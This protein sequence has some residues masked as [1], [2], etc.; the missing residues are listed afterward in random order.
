MAAAADHATLA[1]IELVDVP[2]GLVALDALVKEAEVALY[3]A[4]DIDPGRFL[5]VF[6]GDLASCEAGLAKAIDGGRSDV[7]ESLLLPQAHL[8]LRAALSG[9]LTQPSVASEAQAAL[10]ILQ[11]HTPTGTLAATD[12]ALKAAEVSLLRLR[13]ATDL[14][15][16]GHAVLAGE[17]ADI[18]AALEAAEHG[19]PAGVVVRCRQI[20]RPAQEVY[21][22]AGQ[23]PQG[24]RALRPLDA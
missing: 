19:A 8:L 22:A 20:A 13:F 7:I 3:F 15:G 5:I 16:M 2:S 1:A 10:G 12:R 14:A 18:E 23:R 21:A 24:P 11:C 6:G 9:A 17:Q 4:G